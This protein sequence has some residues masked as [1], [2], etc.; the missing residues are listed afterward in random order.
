MSLRALNITDTNSPRLPRVYFKESQ[1]YDSVEFERLFDS[2]KN[3][4]R[5][6]IDDSIISKITHLSIDDLENDDDSIYNESFNFDKW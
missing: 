5:F 1:I 4:T 2:L 3:H 6:H